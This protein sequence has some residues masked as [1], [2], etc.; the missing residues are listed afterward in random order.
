MARLPFSPSVAGRRG[1]S[2]GPR[3]HRNAWLNC[4]G[5]GAELPATCP[6][7]LMATPSQGRPPYLPGLC[8]GGVM[9]A[10]LLVLRN[11]GSLAHPGRTD[12][13]VRLRGVL[14]GRSKTLAGRILMPELWPNDPDDDGNAIAGAC[15]AALV[16]VG[17][18]AL[19]VLL[20]VLLRWLL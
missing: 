2:A 13:P 9:S 15:G 16:G 19:I 6:A 17:I 1:R 20:L 10:L 11:P 4:A 5:A 7:W 8:R 14:R 12:L 18:V 3:D